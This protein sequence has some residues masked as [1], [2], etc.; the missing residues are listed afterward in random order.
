MKHTT[1]SILP[2]VLLCALLTIGCPQHGKLSSAKNQGTNPSVPQNPIE[3]VEADVL[4]AFG[5]TKG[6]QSPFE[7]ADKI[8]SE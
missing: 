7:A 4:E 2:A 3:L 6:K 1:E 5:L 8:A